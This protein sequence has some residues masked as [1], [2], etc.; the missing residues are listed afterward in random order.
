M[1]LTFF[2]TASLVLFLIAARPDEPRKGLFYHLFYISIAL[3][4]LTKGLIGLVFPGGIIFFYLLTTRRW[5]LLAEMRLPTGIPLFFLA[6]A[7]WFVLVSRKNPEFA[8]FF[9]IHEHFDRFLTE[10]HERNKGMWFPAAM[11]LLLFLPWT[12]LLPLAAKRSIHDRRGG[13]AGD[14]LF[15]LLWIGIIVL[16]FTF[17]KSQLAPYL[18]PALPAAALLLGE[19]LSE[20]AGGRLAPSQHF[21][22]LAGH[23]SAR[24]LAIML[25]AW[26]PLQA[27]A[28][29]LVIAHQKRA[30][31]DLGL[32]FRR[33]APDGAVLASLWFERGLNFY[34]ERRIVLVGGERTRPDELEFGS[35]QG[36]HSF[37][38][39]NR[40][41]FLELWDS[42]RTVFTLM[43]SKD[44][45]EMRGRMKTPPHV[46]GQ[47]PERRNVLVS[48]R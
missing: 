43:E 17:S 19:T 3:A 34:A 48:N 44:L 5:R 2:L 11:F 26:L 7:P 41:S 21:R 45:E 36:D 30:S 15:L 23:G 6:A 4:V 18:L 12:P 28:T 16:F 47:D 33:T 10:S 46:V 38:F 31:R 35:Q 20:I 32:L 9:F 14:R 40:A 1:T 29:T 27:A 39:R 8:R 37:W 13:R 25:I 22:F 42:D 24:L